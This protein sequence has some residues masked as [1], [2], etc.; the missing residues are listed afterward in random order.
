MAP[1]S[2]SPEISSSRLQSELL[3]PTTSHD[4]TASSKPFAHNRYP[5]MALHEA[6]S[7]RNYRR[8]HTSSSATTKSA[9]LC[10]HPTMAPFRSSAVPTNI[11]LLK[12]T[13]KQQSS[14]L[15]ASNR[16]SRTQP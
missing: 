8:P 15:T 4:Y 7:T 14:P 3:T 6:S 13:V 1:P 9:A 10:S 11:S 12:H 16:P 5:T 2:A